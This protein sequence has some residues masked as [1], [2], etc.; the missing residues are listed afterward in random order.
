MGS[1]VNLGSVN[2]GHKGDIE[3]VTGITAGS[4]VSLV[5]NVFPEHLAFLELSFVLG[6]TTA[7][8]RTKKE[9]DADILVE[10]GGQL[11][12]SLVCDD[13]D[14][15]ANKRM[16]QLN[17]LN[18]NAPVFTKELY[19]TTISEILAVN[20]EVFRVQAIDLDI[21]LDN[22]R[23]SYSMLPPSPEDF[24]LTEAGAVTVARRLNYNSQ[25]RYTFS[26]RAEDV[27]GLFDEATVV[28]NIE[29]V[30][31]L[32]PYFHHNLYRAAIPENESG[33]FH[34]ITPGAIAAQDGDTGINETL[35]YR[36]TE[37][38]PPKYAERFTMD[39]SS[40]VVLV[41]TAIDRE[42]LDSALIT[43]S[44]EAS[45]ADDPSKAAHSVVLVTVED[46]NDNAPA[47]SLHAVSATI[48]ENSPVGALVVMATVADAD[49]GGF[50]G[51]LSIVP[52]SAPFSVTSDGAVRVKDSAALDRES[53]GSFIFQV[54]LP[55]ESDPPNR[56]ATMNVNVTLLDQNDNSP[57]FTKAI[58]IVRVTGEQTEGMLLVQVKAEDSDEGQNGEI[59]YSLDVGNKDGYFSINDKSGEI[60]LKKPILMEDK[61]LEFSLFVTA[62]DGGIVS[63]SSF[64]QVNIFAPGDFKPQFTQKTYSGTIEEEQSAGVV[65][66]KVQFRTLGLEV[67]P[68]LQV[69][70]ETDKF[71]ISSDGI[72]TSTTTLD[73]D[74]SPQNYSVGISISDGVTTDQAVV[75]V[76]VT[77]V[78]DN[79]PEFVSGAITTSVLEDVGVGDN[80]TAVPARDKDHG[81]NGDIRYSLEGGKGKF[82]IDPES[83]MVRVAAPLDRESD[84]EFSLLVVARDQGQPA[85]SASA[86]LQVL[87][88]DVNDNVPEFPRTEFRVDVSE[89]ASVGTVLLTLSAADPDE[90]PNG[91]VTYSILMQSPSST[92]AAF[93]LDSS[94]GALRLAQTLDFSVA[95]AYRVTVEAV[96]GGAPALAGNST[97]VIRVVDVNNNPP[98]FIPDR[99]DVAVLENLPSGAAIVTLDVTDR[100][101]DG[102]SNGHF[103][104]TSDTF[105]INTKGVVFLR[106]NVTLDR[107]TRNT[108][109]LQV[110]AVDQ[111]ASGLSATAELKVTVLDYNDN[112][113]QF[114]AFPDPL[115][116]SEGH[117][118]DAAPGE[119]YTFRVTDDDDGPNG[120][121][122]LSFASPEPLFTLR[123]DGTLLVVGP[124]D[125]EGRDS[126]DI[127]ILASDRGTPQRENF[128]TIRLSVG[129]VNDNAPEF[130]AERYSKS[131]LVKEAKE[132]DL[133]LRL[134]AR[135]SDA[136]DNSL[137]TYSFSAGGHP[138]LSMNSETGA[139]TL[140]SDLASVTKDTTITLMA[141]AKDH[142]LPPL[143]STASV[144]INL[145]TSSLVEGVSFASSSYNFTLTE[146][147]PEGAAVG[148]VTAY[149]GNDLY[150]I[151]YTLVTRTH[152]FSIDAHGA[153][154]ANKAL[155]KESQEWYI[156]EVEA[157]DNRVPP[158]SATTMVS[159]Q[160]EDVNEDPRFV[161]DSYT[162]KIFSI[163]FYK[164]PVVYVQATDPDLGDQGKL[165]YSLPVASPYFDVDSSSGLL[166][167][168]SAEALAGQS[169]G[170]EVRATDPGGLY[171]TARVK[172]EVQGSVSSN[173]VVIS[174]NQA[175]NVVENK[176]PEVE[177]ALG[178][179][180]GWTVEV[181]GVSNTNGG[182]S[183]SRTSR[184]EPK[185]YVS[186]IAM[187]GVDVISSEDVKKKL[188]S[189]AD[190]VK[191]ELEMLFGKGL[192]YAVEEE[193]SVQTSDVAVVALG[194]LLGIS[195]LAL[196]VIV[197]L[198]IVKFRRMRKHLEDPHREKFEIDRQSEGFAVG[199]HGRTD[200]RGKPE[201]KDAQPKETGGRQEEAR[202]RQQRP[203]GTERR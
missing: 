54:P 140:A 27:G 132:G 49:Q 57:N 162:A 107:E 124:L 37:V 127:V 75:E 15:F 130:G 109:L 151:N 22:K 178:R 82:S 32:N 68:T 47:F 177:S 44:I 9:L 116:V 106:N 114:G 201:M 152:M 41:S 104:L 189:E 175:A 188:Q 85:M 180:I 38:S 187:D 20:T 97:V 155:D 53:H 18:D 173:V 92:P 103:I 58:Y 62:R 71:A 183:I 87:V 146:N 153:I 102:F 52:E 10:T 161:S 42:E 149:P 193:A 30:D 93:E 31:N 67:P 198:S 19:D 28:I 17:D 77:D 147:R 35:V 128:T 196:I 118:S 181:I 21:S 89:N 63:R 69:V 202:A 5:A 115:L 12:Y 1:D 172:V 16:L 120:E 129:D 171:A 121:V 88:A 14:K 72:F 34:R 65:I 80:V 138:F 55:I 163:A 7:T 3:V 195:M 194:V 123:E 2:E 83:G 48:E 105:D 174:L 46:V 145:R 150:T 51:N 40:G 24:L 160:V 190:A 79:K 185:T 135:D 95:K 74:E 11:Y 191:A 169:A 184:Q 56:V 84:P 203:P 186:F 59:T 126:Y 64:A 133:V 182:T 111:P 23:V 8:V 108:Y 122:T 86:T 100:D 166:Y 176:I 13:I 96:D 33:P 91:S 168:V 76:Q 164:S 139:V 137:I 90:G 45:Q 39:S 141:M 167:V 159:V 154:V 43:V 117:Y 148:V 98:E 50:V 73:Y 81:F 110:T 112:S 199:G 131:I 6:Q 70:T 170:V 4:G 200:S 99:Y 25:K 179:V 36:I 66:L 94:T 113:P 26:V 125:R 192:Q 136:G 61:L 142:G 29:D 143:N 197:V 101:E 119:V 157:I 134:L 156:L 60:T 78:N 144:V 158:T 165:L